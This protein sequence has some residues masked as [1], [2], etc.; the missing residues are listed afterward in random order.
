MD[1]EKFIAFVAQ[2][3]EDVIRLAETKC[4]RA[5][6]RR[7]AFQ[8]LGGSH[9][10][11][12]ESVVEHIAA[13]VYVDEE[14]IFPC[15]DIGVGDVLQD[16]TLLIIGSVAGYQ[17]RPFCKNWTGR[18]GPFVHIVGQPFLNKM[19]GK[20]DNWRSDKPF[21]FITPEVRDR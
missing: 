1:R 6:P 11:V 19:A 8:W 17:P 12:T 9:S 21:V 13:R 14:H 4:G 15:V 5:L 7:F 18:S 2:T 20:Q 16:G 10:V 3:L